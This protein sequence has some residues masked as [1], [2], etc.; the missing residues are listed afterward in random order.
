[1]EAGVK[2]EDGKVSVRY[3][4]LPQV[5]KLR[6]NFGQAMAIQSSV[7]AGLVKS[8]RHTAFTEEME[9]AL[10]QGTFS[11]VTRKELEERRRSGQPMHYLAVFGVEQP[12]HLGHR[13]RVVSHGKLKNIHASLLVNECMEKPPNTLVPLITVL[14]WCRTNLHVLMVDLAR[15]YQALHT[16]QT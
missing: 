11:R 6:E 7:E 5:A 13:L 10:S 14:L 2:V 15:A 8:G 3:S 16:G 4:W 12:G 1:M 9:K